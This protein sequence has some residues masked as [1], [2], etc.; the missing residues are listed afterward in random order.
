MLSAVYSNPLLAK[1]GICPPDAEIP[2]SGK[3]PSVHAVKFKQSST[4]QEADPIHVKTMA[5][6]TERIQRLI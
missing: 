2:H 1:R 3:K 5:H 4:V 6:I